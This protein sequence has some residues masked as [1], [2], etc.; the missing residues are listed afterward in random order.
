LVEQGRAPAESTIQTKPYRKA[1][2]VHRL[3]EAL[4]ATAPVS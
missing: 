3:R 4:T 1:E 2:L